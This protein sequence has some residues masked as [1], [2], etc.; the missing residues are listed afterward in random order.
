M[1]VAV[2]NAQMHRQMLANVGHIVPTIFKDLRPLPPRQNRDVRNIGID[3]VVWVCGYTHMVEYHALALLYFVLLQ[4]LCRPVGSTR[5]GC[6]VLLLRLLLPLLLLLLL[7]LQ[8]LKL[9]LP[10]LMHFRGARPSL[11]FSS[12][13]AYVSNCQYTLANSEEKGREAITFPGLICEQIGPLIMD[14]H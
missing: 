6:D 8:L 5:E 7:L 3:V 14:T 4:I 1:E 10:L 2:R 13:P 9:L 12:P 11:F